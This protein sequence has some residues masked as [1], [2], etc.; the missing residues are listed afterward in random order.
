MSGPPDSQIAAPIAQAI[1]L[2]N[3]GQWAFAET[4]L[5]QV[6]RQRPGEPD[7]LQLLGL[8]RANQGRLGEAEALYRRSLAAK[9]KQ[10]HVQINLGKLLA[11][12]G[13]AAEG[14]AL[15]RAVVRAHPDNVDALVVLGQAQNEAGDTV[16]AE[17]NLRA[18]LARAPGDLTAALSLGSLLSETERPAEGEAVLRDALKR[19][20]PAGMRAALEHN[21]GVALKMQKRHAEALAA[22]DAAIA[23]MPDLPLAEYNRANTLLHLGRDGEAVAG[24]RRYLVR[25]PAN[26]AVHHEL[27]A[28]LYRMGDDAAFLESFAASPPHAAALL[29]HKGG[30][31]IRVGRFEE[32]LDCFERTVGRD[33]G[34]PEA[35]NG[36]GLALAG[37]GRLDD[38][39]VAYETSL[40]LRPDDV[41]TTTNLACLML[42]VGEDRRAL[43]LTEQAVARA[44]FDQAALG[45]HELALRVNRDPRAAWL[46]DY[47][48]HVQVF[49]LAPPDG[50]ADMAAFNTALNRHLDTLHRDRREHIDQTLRRGTQTIEPLF[51]GDNP[52]ILAL[53]ERIEAATTRYIAQMDDGGAHPLT[54]RR[55]EGFRFAGSWSSRLHDEGFHTNHVHPKGWISSCYYVEVPAAAE[56][57][58]A[59]QGWIKFGEPT[60]NTSLNDPVRRTV[61]PVPGRLVLF[62]SYMWHGTVPFRAPTARTT[63]AFDAIP[64]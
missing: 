41:P 40:A 63:I 48:R 5:T 56:D 1:A 45:A 59:Q 15:L 39:I 60:F 9:P 38:A 42:R 43:A 22:F 58:Q 36:K 14:I 31:L 23:R 46:A 27:N 18:A 64:R 35:H 2:M 62:P 57:P 44:P 61:K 55:A 49:D 12:T 6:L 51:D 47:E 32:A 16:F 52:L 13:R 33:A 17:K 8:V 11:M 19:D 29:P 37:L 28:L 4:V 24:Y 26:V 53:R 30:L 20:A 10:P 21:L 7:G 25:D 54:S 50:F 34:N 3:Q